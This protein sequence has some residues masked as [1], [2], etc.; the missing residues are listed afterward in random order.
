MA[1]K[2]RN[3]DKLTIRK[4]E[5]GE[6]VCT[7]KQV[8]LI[9][10]HIFEAWSGDDDGTPRFSGKFHAPNE[11]HAK[12]IE[13]LQ[14]L[15]D[16]LREEWFDGRKMKADHYYLRDGDEEATEELHDGWFVSAGEKQN[17]PPAV[18][19]R[20]KSKIK[21]GGKIHSGTYVNVMFKPW[22][23]DNKFGKKINA[24]LLAVQFHQKGDVVEGQGG[25]SKKDIDEGFDEYDADEMDEG[26]GDGL[27]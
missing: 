24:N 21:A 9:H 16:H 26:D 1:F 3:T 20:D 23:Q 27:D 8:R 11:T 19:D 22:K 2:P 4:N 5:K 25:V 13:I 14:E 18:I 12:E 6:Y 7:L 17:R 15:N 10:E